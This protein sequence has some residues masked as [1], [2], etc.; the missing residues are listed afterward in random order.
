MYP[1]RAAVLDLAIVPQGPSGNVWRHPESSWLRKGY[2][3]YCVGARDAAQYPKIHGTGPHHK[4][5]SSPKYRW[6]CRWETS[7]QRRMNITK[8]APKL[9]QA[10]GSPKAPVDVR[11]F[12]QSDSKASSAGKSILILICLWGNTLLPRNCCSAAGTWPASMA[13]IWTQRLADEGCGPPARVN[14][15]QF[16]DWGLCT[17][18]GW[19]EGTPA[20]RCLPLPALFHQGHSIWTHRGS[21]PE[22]GRRWVPACTFFV[23]IIQSWKFYCYANS[24]CLHHSVIVNFLLFLVFSKEELR[25][26]LPSLKAFW[27]FPVS[28]M[29]MKQN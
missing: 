25:E 28:Q 24:Y 20:R 9:S 21:V 4:E 19:A 13:L 23:E 14:E 26:Y 5:L 17:G 10:A 27:F 29:L 12:G 6:C 3:C 1:C 15:N 22:S 11:C 2:G 16:R 8:L 18:G 7:V